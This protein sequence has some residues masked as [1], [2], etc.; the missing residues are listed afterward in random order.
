MKKFGF[1]RLSILE[2]NFKE[3]L[4][5]KLAKFRPMFFLYYLK[6]YLKNVKNTHWRVLLLAW[7][8]LVKLQAKAT[9]LKVTVLYGCFSCFSINF[10]R[11]KRGK[12]SWNALTNSKLTPKQLENMVIILGRWK[13]KATLPSNLCEVK[14]N[15][16][17]GLR[18]KR[19]LK[20]L[21]HC[22]SPKIS[23]SENLQ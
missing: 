20:I 12:L 8:V 3:L 15:K 17:E 13:H 21:N 10:R 22:S 6:T 5:K 2:S 7:M 14:I 19:F 23:K 4:Q 9:L 11:V 16:R 1:R 18:G